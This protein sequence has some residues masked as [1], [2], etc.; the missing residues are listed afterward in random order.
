[1][2]NPYNQQFYIQYFFFFLSLTLAEVIY[3]CIPECPS[4]IIHVP[5]GGKYPKNG[6]MK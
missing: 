3:D 6:E 4:V 1:M 2:I 5:M